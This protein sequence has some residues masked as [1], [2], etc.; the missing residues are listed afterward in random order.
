MRHLLKF[1]CILIIALIVACEQ[2]EDQFTSDP[3][4]KLR[5]SADSIVFDTLFTSV[6]SITKR[7]WIYNDFDNAIRITSATL[8][9]G[10]NSNYSVILNGKEGDEIRNTPIYGK[11]SVQALVTVNINPKDENLPFLVNDFLD[12]TTNGN[13]QFVNLVAWGQDAHFIKKGRL[14]CDQVWTNDRPYVL[15][16]SVFVE[17]GCK[18]GI[19][20]GAR[21]YANVNAALI[22]SGSLEANGTFEERILFTNSRQ[23]EDYRNAPGQWRGILF[24]ETSHNNTINCTDIRNAVTGIWLGTPDDDT[25]AD[26]VLSNSKIENM[27]NFGL[28]AFTSDVY[29]YNTLINNCGQYALANLAGGNYRYEHCT[30][31]NFSFDFFREDAAVAFSDNLPISAD[32]ILVGD[33]QLDMV[34]SIVWGSLKEEIIFSDAGEQRFEL[35]LSNNIFKSNDALIS[36]SNNILNEDPKFLDPRNYNYSLD[37]LSIAK[38]TGAQLGILQDLEGKPRDSKPD[39]GAF[40]RIE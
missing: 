35:N 6:G 40:E 28:V 26:L 33:F 19:T 10:S 11:D 15:L 7:L 23:D 31:A 25:E 29:A 4:V 14:T 21:I 37:T 20:A 39:I 2:E 12:F 3:S 8:R 38:D 18:L 36:G 1:A 16:D 17:E 13:Q 22:V 9:N 27:S 5:F 32:E 34:N 30:F 24:A